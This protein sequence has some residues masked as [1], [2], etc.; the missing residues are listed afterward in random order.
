L[1][2][3]D[4]L[5]LYAIVLPYLRHIDNRLPENVY[6]WRLTTKGHKGTGA[7]FQDRPMPLLPVGKRKEIRE[8]EEWYQAW[9]E[10]DKDTKR[11]IE[12][13]GY[14]HMAVS[15]ITAY[16]ENI[17]HDVL[18]GTLHRHMESDGHYPINLLIDI[19]SQW[20]ILP[21][22]GV[23]I[24]RGIPQGNDISS[25]LGNLYLLPLDEALCEIEKTDGIRYLRYMDDVKIL[26]K[27]R[28]SALKALFAMNKV[29]RELQ[30]NVQGSKTNIYEGQEIIELL[31]HRELEEANVV[32]DE[33][34]KKGRQG[35]ISKAHCIAY[36]NKLKPFLLKL[37]R[38]LKDSKD[39]RLFK[40]LLTG[41]TKIRR[42]TGV[43]R[44][45]SQIILVP[46]L[47]DKIVSYFRVF[48]G[49]AKIGHFLYEHISGQADVLEY[50]IARFLEV[51]RFKDA[52]PPKL[53]SILMKYAEDT[54]VHW[55]I[56]RNALIELSYLDLTK[57]QLKTL[58]LLSNSETNY[59]V[60]RAI[61][62]CLMNAPK[63]WRH[64]IIDH[65]KLDSDRRVSLFAK[66]L[67]D[68]SDDL[69]TQKY[70][71][72]NLSTLAM[73][74]SPLLV[75]ESYKFILMRDS[76]H[77]FILEGLCICLS[78]INSSYYPLPVRYRIQHSL[79][80]A[81]DNLRTIRLDNTR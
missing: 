68:L 65:T 61:L 78:K 77:E 19:L 41:F 37:P 33:I 5:V 14:T 27:S 62:L 40:R 67:L 25:Y 23:R 63:K 12:K 22:H 80:V 75:D 49:G 28:A 55:A 17:S 52:H 57:S 73:S 51:F 21:P 60:K 48:K 66:F 6:S 56:R 74:H 58:R 72:N 30:L 9:P 64:Y 43:P 31:S 69:A 54:N 11:F 79:Q 13:H 7:L 18:R 53:F 42:A 32:V 34:L 24:P 71:I 4:F 47:T 29:L 20:T 70:E 38:K 8:F 35:W 45:M 2:F 26:A 81:K 1:D 59:A 3:E 50:Q 76:R 15:D 46:G 16:F 36:E 39:V 44:A 10:F